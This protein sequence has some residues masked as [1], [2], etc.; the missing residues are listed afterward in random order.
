MYYNCL[1]IVC[2]DMLASPGSS[3][4]FQM[5]HSHRLQ[6]LRQCAVGGHKGA[7]K[8]YKLQN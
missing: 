6:H 1:F 5:R 8:S 7:Y 4:N 2:D 3:L